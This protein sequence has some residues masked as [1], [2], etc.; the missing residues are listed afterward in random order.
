MSLPAKNLHKNKSV[1]LIAA[2][3]LGIAVLL[4]ACSQDAET[5]TTP[6]NDTAITPSDISQP[7]E[8]VATIEKVPDP[9]EAASAYLDAWA[10]SDYNA[11]YNMLTTLSRDAIPYEDFEARYLNVALQ[12]VVVDLDYEILQNIVTPT[13]AQV[14]YH[15]TLYSSLV[16]ALEAQTQMDL[17]LEDG[18]WKV[19]WNETMIL[20]ELAGG[21]YLSMETIW[22]T[23]GI[24]YD[25]DG[26]TLAANT[27]AVALNIVPSSVEE[28][29]GDQILSVM[30]AVSNIN[31]PYWDAVIFD[32]DNPFVIP[33]YEIPY[34]TFEQYENRISRHYNAIGATAYNTRLDYIGE[35]GGPSVGWVG[36]IPAEDV[37]FWAE[38]GYPSGAQIGRSGIEA[39]AEEML[40][41]K[42]SADLYVITPEGLVLTRLASR[43]TV[44]SQSVYSTL[45]D[46]LQLWAEL[47]LQG[48]T[49]A[50][51]V[52]ER[53]TGKVLAIASSPSYNPNYADLNNPNSLWDSYFPDNAG[54][55]FNRATQ[56]QY[57]PGSIFKVITTSAALE[58]GMYTPNDVLNCE[59]HWYGPDNTVLDDWTFEKERAASGNLTLVEGIMRSCN[60]WFYE[61]GYS[62]YTNGKVD[63]IAEMARGF[64]LGK[65]TGIDVFPEEDGQITNPDE[66]EGLQSGSQ[67][68]YLATVQGIGQSDTL[69]TPIQAAV[70]TAAIGNGG[71][72]YRPQMIERVENTAGESTF[73]FTPVVN[74][75][76]PISD[77]TLAAIR[78]GMLLVTQNTSGT[79]Y[80]TFANRVIQVY[81][82][83]GTAQ[84]SGGQDPHAWFIGYTDEQDPNRPDIAMAIIVENQGDGSEFAAPIFR[85]LMEVYFYGQPTSQFRWESRIGEVDERYFMTPEELEAL[86]EQENNNNNNNNDSGN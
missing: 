61:I 13:Q 36:P 57:P 41:G 11:M 31:A 85:R 26:N 66:Q 7:G 68:W 1:L 29:Q 75:T 35:A 21:N 17:H 82:K 52:L 28:D 2:L 14:A 50:A 32:E 55:F 27:R 44:P 65:P 64:G 58:S 74:G 86:E 8:L 72:L 69:I 46:Q 5:P 67:P 15:T 30:Q 81:G 59:H 19:V 24:I 38:K 23:R 70:Y 3:I 42:P 84:T 83:T 37:E 63:A 56:G 54:Y 6:A 76:L 60:I 48:F 49:G 43:E 78:E 71:T 53:D 9:N 25:K 79:A 40:A 16:G 51:V 73:E 4:G 12:A 10:A 20:P 80:N 33:L 47:S 62:L 39:W 22:P 45:D 34:S 18:V 77:N